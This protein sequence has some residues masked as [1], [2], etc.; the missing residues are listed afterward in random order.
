MITETQTSLETR[1]PKSHLLKSHL[2]V[3]LLFDLFPLLSRRRHRQYHIYILPGSTLVVR[4]SLQ[5]DSPSRIFLEPYLQK[6]LHIIS[7][8]LPSESP[9][10]PDLQRQG[11]LRVRDYGSG[12]HTLNLN[13]GHRPLIQIDSRPLTPGVYRNVLL[14]LS[15]LT[16]KKKW[17]T[18]GCSPY[19]RSVLHPR[20]VL[21]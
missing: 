5:R 18:P 9:I 7:V 6:H 16:I 1:R 21:V 11:R 13:P 2:Q 19:R 10:L 8:V 12:G 15:D 17:Y 3:A 4:P 14:L 20:V